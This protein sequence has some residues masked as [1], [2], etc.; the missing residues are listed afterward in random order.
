MVCMPLCPIPMGG[1]CMHVRV[2]ACR[3]ISMGPASAVRFASSA[4]SPTHTTFL[5]PVALY[6]GQVNDLVT[7]NLSASASQL[8]ILQVRPVG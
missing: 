6:G 4:S 2:H 7:A 8:E 3:S 1:V 5:P